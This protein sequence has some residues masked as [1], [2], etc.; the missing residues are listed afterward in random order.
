MNFSPGVGVFL[1]YVTNYSSPFLKWGVPGG[2]ALITLEWSDWLSLDDSV[3]VCVCVRGCVCGHLVQI[4]PYIE[5]LRR[6]HTSVTFTFV[7]P[8]PWPH[9]KIP[10]SNPN[11]YSKCVVNR[12]IHSVTARY[13]PN[14]TLTFVWPWPHQKIPHSS[15]ALYFNFGTNRPILL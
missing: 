5:L 8:W 4:N 6:K 12:P 7:W 3:D 11:L 2:W 10:H 1:F 9:E 14:V 15:P 13:K